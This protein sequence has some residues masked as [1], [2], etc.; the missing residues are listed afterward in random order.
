[1]F[2]I[3]VLG[4]FLIFIERFKLFFAF[5]FFIVVSSELIFKHNCPLTL[6]E[7]KLREKLNL[8]KDRN[9]FVNRSLKKLFNFTLPEKLISVI[10]GV[11]YIISIIILISYFL[12]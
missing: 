11:Y 6:L 8:K 1:M 2:L 12:L 3:G 10:L 9:Y 7:D 5:F 4:F